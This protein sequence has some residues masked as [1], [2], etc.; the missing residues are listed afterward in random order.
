MTDLYSTA[1]QALLDY[2]AEGLPALFPHPSKQLTASDDTVLDNGHD[3]YGIAYPGAFPIMPA[4]SGFYEVN[5]EVLLD[6]F[7]RFKTTSEEAWR[8][9]KS[10]RGDLFNLL[11]LSLRGETLG[12]ADRVKR[13]TVVA[14]DRPRYIPS[15]KGDQEGPP[16]FIAQVLVVTI[17]QV[18]VRTK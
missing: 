12:A 8:G 5:W 2:I 11:A 18:F 3:H 17:T 16:A 14:E 6:V 4:G 1:E 13:L 10:Y 9:F 15:A 7:Y